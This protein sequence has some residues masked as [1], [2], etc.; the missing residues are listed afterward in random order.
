MAIKIR[1]SALKHGITEAQIREV[2]ADQ[3]T[4][5][6]FEMHSERDDDDYQEM[7]VGYS[8]ANV[9]LEVAVKYSDD[10]E[11]VF[12]ANRVTAAYRTLYEEA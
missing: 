9:L 2:L 7:A 12:H 10:A 5:K 3:F 11:I 4:T 1:K 6:F 8:Q